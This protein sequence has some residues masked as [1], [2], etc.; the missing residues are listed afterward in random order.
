MEVDEPLVQT[1]SGNASALNHSAMEPSGEDTW[2]MIV[3]PVTS[4]ALMDTLLAQMETLTSVCGFLSAR[5]P[6]DLD[7]IEQYFQN[8]PQK[9]IFLC[10]EKTGR[11]H[12]IALTR[13]KF[14]CALA[15]AKF[16]NAKID[17][18]TYEFE[19]AGAYGEVGDVCQDP[20][21]L[22]DRADAEIAFNANMQRA[23]IQ[24]IE[25]VSE[26][27]SK[28]NVIR[29]KHITK[30]LDNLTIASK[31]QDAKNLSRIHLR[32]G[33]CE[34]LRRRLGASPSSYDIALKSASTLLKNAE[35][36]YKGAARLAR[37]EAATDEEREASTK[38]A[39]AAALLGDPSKL[40]ER[41][42]LDRSRA[43]DILEDMS[44][45]GLLLEEDMKILRF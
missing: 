9:E 25:T 16:S 8:P 27:S 36:Y 29:W 14:K 20:Q 30:A 3:E 5:R 24:F 31:L 43:Q 26:D 45:E 23:S 22:C 33:D 35:I 2:A 11:E 41:I 1:A 37:A 19:L 18:P 38:E 39:V 4:H 34:L 44:E 12:E 17:I 7:W 21:A 40:C 15:D 10:A 13:A 42:E 6:W 28:M 32:R